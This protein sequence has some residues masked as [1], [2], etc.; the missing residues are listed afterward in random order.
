MRLPNGNDEAREPGAEAGRSVT[1]KLFAS[2]GRYLPAGSVD[3]SVQVAL[4]AEENTALDLL[5]RFQVP[6][7]TGS[8]VMVNGSRLNSE[9]RAGEALRDG[10]VVAIMNWTE[11]GGFGG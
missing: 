5:R 2:L 11:E 8:V 10:D 3:S 6:L 7:T 9:Q 1:L 4:A